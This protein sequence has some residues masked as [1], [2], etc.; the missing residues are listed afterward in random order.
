MTKTETVNDDM[1]S[2]KEVCKFLSEYAAELLGCGATCIRIEKNV[3]RMAEK[4]QTKV[5][6]TIMPRHIHL[7]VWNMDG[8]HSY[9]TIECVR[10]RSISFEVNSLLS[11]LSWAV[12]DGRTG[13]AEAV[14][15]L[16]RM[17]EVK[18]YNEWLVLLL[19]S[20]A[21]ASFCRLFGG[22]IAAMLIVFVCT[23]SG[24]RLKQVLLSYKADVRFVFLCAAFFSSVIGAAGYL[25]GIST[26]TPNIALGTSVLYLIPGIPYINSVNDLIDGHYIMSFCRFA[27]AAILT[28]CLSIGFCMGMILMGI[29]WF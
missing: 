21:N 26:H 25:P 23:L 18:P 7:T 1:P 16:E 20:L 6:M 15:E 4:W 11:R 14:K 24:Y 28:G 22:D 5:Q 17:A 29:E 10:H 12:A 9:S 27:D 19:V 8:Q 13:F 3:T 2:V